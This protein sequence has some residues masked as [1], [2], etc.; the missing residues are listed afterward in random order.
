MGGGLQEMSGDG[1]YGL[2]LVSKKVATEGAD[3]RNEEEGL[4]RG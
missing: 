3:G 4:E 2:A 1:D